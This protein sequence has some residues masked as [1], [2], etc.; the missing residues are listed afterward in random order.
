VR[1]A[2]VHLNLDPDGVLR[3]ADLERALTALRADGF[4]VIAGD[5]DKLPPTRREIELLHDGDDVGELML[6]AESACA[7]ALAPSATAVPPRALAVSFIS[8]GSYEDAI[9]IIRAF[10]LEPEVEELRFDDEDV[11]VLIVPPAA[12]Q[13]DLFGKLQT[14]LEAALNREVH[15][16]TQ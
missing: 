15:V 13:R 11:A 12:L 5:L 1:R 4:E 10:G 2:V 16:C 3:V 14:A 9:G 6:I 7:A 8:H